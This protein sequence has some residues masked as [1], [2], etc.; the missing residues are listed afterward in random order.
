MPPVSSPRHI[1]ISGELGSGKT[2]VAAELAARLGFPVVSTGSLQREIARSLEMSTLEANLHAE[3]DW[4]IDD[5]IDGMTVRVAREATA[6]IVF[7]SRMA[8]HFV[9]GALKVRLTVDPYVAA[10][11]VVGRGP[12]AAE[13]YG[14]VEEAFRAILDRSA[15]EGRRFRTIYGADISRLANFDLVLDTSEIGVEQAVALIARAH[16]GSP[17]AHRVLAAPRSIVPAFGRVDDAGAG[18]AQGCASHTGGGLWDHPRVA[19]VHARP[20]YFALTGEAALAGAIAA[21]EPLIPVAV[22][23]EGDAK[24]PWGEPASA[25]VRSAGADGALARWEAMTG[26]DLKG[27]RHYLASHPRP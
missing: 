1:A 6:P 11:R 21:G 17:V 27:F 24:T 26:V 8:W 5:R 19:V 9:P 2:S 3:T 14:S 13:H 12:A 7:D 23:A 4:S 20:F 10:A 15:S 22:V 16:A 25:V 18:L